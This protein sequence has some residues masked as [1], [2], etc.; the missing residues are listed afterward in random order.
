MGKQGRTGIPQALV[1]PCLGFL[2]AEGTVASLWLWRP[3]SGCGCL[4]P[5][6]LLG[7]A[8]PAVNRKALCRP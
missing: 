1:M 5:P 2:V 7:K 3:D 4:L 8:S 6:L